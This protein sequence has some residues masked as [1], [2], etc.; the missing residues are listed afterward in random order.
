VRQRCSGGVVNF[1]L[2]VAI[3]GG[4]SARKYLVRDEYLN[5]IKEEV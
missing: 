4:A 3:R 5:L 1:S 2:R